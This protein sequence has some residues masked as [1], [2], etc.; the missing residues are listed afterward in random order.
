MHPQGRRARTAGEMN[1]GRGAEA[2]AA[3]PLKCTTGEVPNPVPAIVTFVPLVAER[4]EN[5]TSFGSTLN[6]FAVLVVPPAFV[7]AIGPSTAAFGTVTLSV[8]APTPTV[9]AATTVPLNLTLVV[10][11]KVLPV[12][13][14]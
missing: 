3:L 9:N 4:G 14:M 5:E 2:G 12:R 11:V 6:G 8:V 1:D 7:T 13:M 10:P